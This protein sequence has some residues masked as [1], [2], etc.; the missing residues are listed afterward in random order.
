FS[1]LVSSLEGELSVAWEDLDAAISFRDIETDAG[2]MEALHHLSRAIRNRREVQFEY[3]KLEAAPG[4][5]RR[6]PPAGETRRVQPYHLACVGN[7]WYLFG[8]DLMRQAI[9]KFVPTRMSHLRVLETRF[10]RPKNFS[11]DKL[12]PGSF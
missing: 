10:Q 5:N 4:D 7:Q 6:G 11:V 8:Y 2:D 12:L 9:R 3:H 1:K